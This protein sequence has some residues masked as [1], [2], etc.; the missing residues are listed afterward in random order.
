MWGTE[1]SFDVLQNTPQV[2]PLLVRLYDTH[3]LYALAEDNASGDACAELTTIMVDLLNIRLSPKESELI[4]DV[5]LALMKKAEADLKMALSERLSAMEHVPLRIILS[6]ANDDVKIADPVLRKSPVLQ[7]MDLMYILQAQGVGHGR[8]IALRGGLSAAIID[9]LVDMHDRQISFNLSGNENICLTA[10]AFDEISDMAVKD[11]DMAQLL[12]MRED[13]PQDIAGKMYEFVSAELKNTLR[14]R[15]GIGAEP[16]IAVLEDIALEI[17]N[18]DRG[19]ADELVAFAQNQMRRGELHV[20]TMIA[21]LRRGQ[22]A[23]FL[24]QFS[25]YCGLP[26]TTVKAMV[27]QESGRG[28]AIACKAMDV[29]KADFVSL[30]LL[31]ERFRSNVKR[32]VNHAE[33]TRVMTMYDEI[34]P[35]EARTIL[36]NSRH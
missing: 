9:M 5:L 20:S 30:Y 23:T 34:N 32:M 13:L 11:R 10:H 31:T 27:R 33:L 22:H 25:V 35:E 36:K 21:T 15:F 16:A 24:A 3:N 12:L 19:P 8:S 2:A 28:L 18:P 1:M 14:A 26:S 7:D 4:T 17:R 29:T 6:L